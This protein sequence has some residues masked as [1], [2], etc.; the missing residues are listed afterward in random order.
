MQKQHFFV[1]I[2]KDESP[3]VSIL[4]TDFATDYRVPIFSWWYRGRLRHVTHSAENSSGLPEQNL[5]F[6]NFSLST[7]KGTTSWG[8]EVAH[9]DIRSKSANQ[10]RTGNEISDGGNKILS[11]I[12]NDATRWRHRHKFT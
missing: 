11:F 6:Q 3:S 4:S 1:Y 7:E 10:K 9:C 2:R 8:L 5:A 12:K